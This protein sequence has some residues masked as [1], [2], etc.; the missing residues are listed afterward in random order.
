M[1]IIDIEYVKSRMYNTL[2]IITDSNGNNMLD[3]IRIEETL[4]E[5]EHLV[6]SY[7]RLVSIDYDNMTKE[8]ME[9]LRPHIFNIFKYYITEENITEVS[10]DK[11]ASTMEYLKNIASGRAVLKTKISKK[12]GIRQFR[13]I[14]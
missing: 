4:R 7:C 2:P 1:N 9:E 8:T 3:E 12:S 11:Y 5:A 13:I 6:L 14:V 10:K